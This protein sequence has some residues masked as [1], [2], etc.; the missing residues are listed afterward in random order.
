MVTSSVQLEEAVV[1]AM[2]NKQRKISVLSAVSTVDT[3]DLQVPSTSINNMLGGRVAGVI[4]LQTSGE[5]GKNIS[6]FWVR[7]MSTF[8]SK[9]S[10]PK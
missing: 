8:Y 3:K 1:T 7:G 5:P 10:Y 9:L 4:S 2:G 6:E